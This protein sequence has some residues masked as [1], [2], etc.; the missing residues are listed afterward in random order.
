MPTSSYSSAF[1]YRPC[2]N[3][4]G[5][6]VCNLVLL[7]EVEKVFRQTASPRL[8]STKLTL[9]PYI[10]SETHIPEDV[11]GTKQILHIW[12]K[13]PLEVDENSSLILQLDANAFRSTKNYTKI[14]TIDSID[15]TLMDLGFLSG[16]DKLIELQFSNI[17]NI[18]QCLP[19]LPPLPKL[20]Y[21]NFDYCTGVNE[22]IHY[23]TLKNGLKDVRFFADVNNIHET[24]NDATVDRIMDWL[25]ISSATTLKEM[26]IR[27]MNQVTQVPLKIPS[28]TALRT[29]SLYHNNISIIKS[30]SFSFSVPVSILD[31][32]GNEIKEIEA[33][34]FKG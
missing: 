5:N 33:G 3:S 10:F 25:L 11:F 16:F 23:P 19:S 17:Y 29:L 12:I 31:L 14:F 8:A 15:C 4:N 6:V 34:A 13:F 22:L 32:D 7:E 28:F 24:Y 21:L 18:Q 20:T 26:T 2:N 9:Q 27:G 30:G 1:D